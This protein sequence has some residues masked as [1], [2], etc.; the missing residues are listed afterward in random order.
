MAIISTLST[1][2]YNIKAMNLNTAWIQKQVKSENY[3]ISSHADEEMQNDKISILEIESALLKCEILEEYPQDPRG[4]S[5]LV[6]GYGQEGYPIHIV[7][8]KT[9]SGKLRI[10]TVYIPA[11][12]KWLNEKTRRKK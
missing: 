11:L 8:G 12:P 4:S 3:E 1:K 5:C 7:C 2:A 10:I 9:K 6:L